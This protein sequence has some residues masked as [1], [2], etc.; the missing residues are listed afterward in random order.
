MTS[1]R[2]F[3]KIPNLRSWQI[4]IA[5]YITIV[6]AHTFVQAKKCNNRCFNYSKVKLA[7]VSHTK[8]VVYIVS[9]INILLSL[10]IDFLKNPVWEQTC[11]DLPGEKKLFLTRP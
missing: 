8:G 9:D 5:Y 3:V 2:P 1:G 4:S 11:S 6:P 7:F 10:N